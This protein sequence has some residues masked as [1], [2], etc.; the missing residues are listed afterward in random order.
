M[1]AAGVG[2]IPL[3]TSV[4]YVRSKARGRLFTEDTVP[5]A[6]VGLVLG[7]LAYPDGTPS[8]F[9]AGRLDLG[10][11]LLAAGRVDVLLVSGDRTP[12][13]YD[14]PGAMVR[15]LVAAGVPE[16]RIVVDPSGFDTYDSC[17][18][19]RDVYGATRLTVI[20]QSYHLPRAVGTARAVGLDA[21]GVGDDTVRSRRFSWTKG[22]IREQFACLKTIVDLGTDRRPVID[23]PT[24]ALHQALAL[25]PAAALRD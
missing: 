25:G 1:L 15:H 16:S 11:R 7:A 21:V 19:A 12:P 20:T 10:Y 8:S 17:V 24:D 18:R 23:A 13:D 6:P 14:E 9:L 2:V 3:A 4:G 22:L 5:Y